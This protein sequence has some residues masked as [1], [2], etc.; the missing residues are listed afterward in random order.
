MS[1]CQRHKYANEEKEKDE[2]TKTK[3]TIVSN[4]Q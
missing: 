2:Q 3:K 1:F 4:E